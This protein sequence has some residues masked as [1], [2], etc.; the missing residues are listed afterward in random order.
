MAHP[1]S[2]VCEYLDS[3]KGVT[4]CARNR[5]VLPAPWDDEI[6]V[7][8]DAEPAQAENYISFGIKP[9]WQRR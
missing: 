7:I 4:T 3:I 8:L 2:F 1:V 9:E 6:R 5:G